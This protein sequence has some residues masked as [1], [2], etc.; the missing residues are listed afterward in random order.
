MKRALFIGRFQP[1]HHGHQF[2]LKKL[3]KKFGEVVVVIGSS[4]DSFSSENPFTCGER[5]DMIRASFNKGEL[6]RIILVPVPDINNNTIWVDHVL[7]HIPSVHEVYSNNQ[8]VKMLFSKHGIL[9]KSIDFFDRGTKEGAHIR[10]LMVQGD[11]SWKKHV[12]KKT[13]EYLD[14]I[15]A[16]KR[17][18]KIERMG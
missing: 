10:N 9:V 6:A 4:E 15:E 1:F 13:V 17:I 3:L 11:Q 8:L 5:I 18:R 7:M 2:A 16:E 14:T 12:P